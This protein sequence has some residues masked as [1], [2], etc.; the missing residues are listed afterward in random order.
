MIACEEVARSVASGELAES[1][2][3]R[4]LALRVHLLMCRHCRRYFRQLSAIDDAARERW[5][6]AGSDDPAAL[7]RLERA[8]R[9]DSGSGPVA[10]TEESEE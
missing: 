1:T 10:L 4:R 2:L 8:I 3:H 9:F 6:A 5:G 7:E